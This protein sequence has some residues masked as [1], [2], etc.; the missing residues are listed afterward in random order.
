MCICAR[1]LLLILIL[2]CVLLRIVME[3]HVRLI[4]AIKFYL[5]IN[6]LKLKLFSYF[7]V[8]PSRGPAKLAISRHSD[9]M[10]ALMWP[11]GARRRY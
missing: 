4:C 5:L 11:P 1:V 3:M 8:S 6:L 7:N 2:S 10:V 9:V